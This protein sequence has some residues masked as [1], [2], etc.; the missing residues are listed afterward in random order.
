MELHDKDA[1]LQLLLAFVYNRTVASF[2]RVVE[3]TKL[4]KLLPSLY[5]GR[6]VIIS[7]ERFE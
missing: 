6:T 3:T 4:P 5:T 7:F 1:N 2:P